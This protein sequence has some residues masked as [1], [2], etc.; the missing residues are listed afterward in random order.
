M[1]ADKRPVLVTG[2]GIGGL[3]AA[4]ALVREGFEVKVIE[5][6][7]LIGEIGAGIQLSPNAFAAC[8]ALGVGEHLRAHAVYTEEMR[9]FDAIDAQPVA[10]IALGQQFRAYFGNPYAVIHR[11]DIHGALLEGVRSRAGQIEFLSSTRIVSVAQSDD[12]VTLL[13]AQGQSHAGQ[14]VIACDGVRS[15]IRQQYVNDSIRV[16]GHVVYRAVIDAVDFPAAWRLHAPCIWVG[17]NCHLVHYPLKGGEKF[18]LAATFHSRTPEQWG[19]RE[20]DAAELLNYFAGTC[21]AVMQMLRVPQHWSRWSTA[22]RDPIIQWSFGRAT[23]LGDAAHPMVQ[24]L[25]QGACMACEDAVTLGLA[26]RHENADWPRALALYERSRVARSARVV[27]S[28]REMGRIYHAQGVERLVRND[29][30]RD[31]PQQGF[32]AALQWLYG[33]T[34]AKSLKLA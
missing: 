23:L 13:D 33:W 10:S 17:P 3:A 25:A 15:V 19:T 28:A 11:A 26:L 8:D 20:G 5:Q 1:S 30:W 12:G 14:A 22:D 21:D 4:L 32:Y 16:S 18:N 29:M 2:G 9:M 31:R 6:S 7:S 27:L 34:A 24:Y